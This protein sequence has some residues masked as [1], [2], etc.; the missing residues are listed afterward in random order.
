MSNLEKLIADLNKKSKDS[1]RFGQE[2]LSDVP[3]IPMENA[4]LEYLFRG[5]FPE[6]S[7]YELYGQPSGGKTVLGYTILKNWQK[8]LH[9]RDRKAVL[10]DYECSHTDRWATTL[11]VDMKN[12]IVW[13]PMSGESAE[14]LFNIIRDF[15]KT[16]EVGFMMLDSVGSLVPKN[17]KDK[18]FEEKTMG[19]VAAPLTDF[20]NSFNPLMSRYNITFVAIN[21]LR[22][23]FNDTYSKGKSPGGKAFKHHC[24]IR[25]NLSAGE[26]FDHKGDSCSRYSDA[27]GH[28]ITIVVEKNKKTPNDR[29]KTTVT[30]NYLSGIDDFKDNIEFA[31]I[32]GL[33]RGSGAWYEIVDFETGE[34]L[35][36]K[37]N[38]MKQVFEYYRTNPEKYA[39]LVKKL[40]EF[41]RGEE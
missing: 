30:F 27:S 18:D 7:M 23:D 14:E 4:R 26:Y 22:E 2:D 25:L 21:Q 29:K 8:L 31:V 37:L 28:H 1:V 36:K 24:D 3:R 38:G 32:Y 35:G 10:F 11:G 6:G 17:R 16:G 33:I 20:V 9:N 41:V 12:V 40:N 34:L 39:A 5:G 15:A 19:G 13:R